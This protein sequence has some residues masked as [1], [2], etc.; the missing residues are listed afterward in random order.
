MAL[1]GLKGRLQSGG[2]SARVWVFRIDALKFQDGNHGRGGD[3]QRS[4]GT[5]ASLLGEDDQR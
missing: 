5:D 1:A 2:R 4:A 3:L